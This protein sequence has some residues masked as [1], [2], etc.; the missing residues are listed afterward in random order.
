MV[1]LF[2]FA[3]KDSLVHHRHAIPNV[4][5]VQ[6]VHRTKLALI[7][8]VAIHVRELVELVLNVQL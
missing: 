3:F 8:N 6:N 2:V 7:K 4:F 5:K 1:K